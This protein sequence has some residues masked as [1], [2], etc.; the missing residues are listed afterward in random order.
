MSTE[1]GKTVVDVHSLKD[2]RTAL[3]NHHSAAA[4]MLRNIDEKLLNPDP[5]PFGGFP[6][7]NDTADY[8]ST[9]VGEY[10]AK[11]A[12]LQ[13]AI[14][15]ARTAT[16]SILDTYQT[17]EARNDASAKDIARAVDPVAAALKGA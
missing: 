9:M 6:D 11:V 2:F 3:D 8:Y 13:K 16:R 10:R 7:G 4:A 15:A 17:V 14:E 1:Y 12:R 5:R